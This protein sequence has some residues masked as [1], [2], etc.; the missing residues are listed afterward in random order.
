MAIEATRVAEEEATAAEA[1]RAAAQKEA[2]T[3]SAEVCDA[4]MRGHLFCDLLPLFTR[5]LVS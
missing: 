3:A 1:A 4:V 5:V 2:E